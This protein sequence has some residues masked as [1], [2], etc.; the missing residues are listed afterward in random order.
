MSAGVRAVAQCTY[1]AAAVINDAAG[2][3]FGLRKEAIVEVD[4]V[5]SPVLGIQIRLSLRV[6]R[7]PIVPATLLARLQ[8][9]NPG[10]ENPCSF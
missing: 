5:A 9:P 3:G 8:G 7:L 2:Y 4:F 1:Q 6:R 10:L